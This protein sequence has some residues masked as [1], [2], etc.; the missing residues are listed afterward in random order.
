MNSVMTTL[1]LLVSSKSRLPRSVVLSVSGHL[2]CC[3]VATKREGLINSLE[4]RGTVL[5]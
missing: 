3:S 2:P 4:E 5:I 1:P